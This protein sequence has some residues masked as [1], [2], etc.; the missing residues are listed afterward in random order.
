MYMLMH[1][2]VGGRTG[3]CGKGVSAY[4]FADVLL[5][6]AERGRIDVCYII[7]YKVHFMLL[8]VNVV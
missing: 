2:H 8:Y 1:M 4:R 7:I 3:A 5:K 6:L